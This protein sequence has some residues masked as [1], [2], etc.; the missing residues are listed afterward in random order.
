MLHIL[1]ACT[2]P[3]NLPF[4]AE[5]LRAWGS[6]DFIWHVR[7]D[8]RGRHVGGQAVKNKLLDEIHD[9]W[10]LVLD[11]DTVVH[12]ALWRTFQK[13]RHGDAA[14]IVVSQQ[15]SVLGVLHAAHVNVMIG[16]IDIGQ[17]IIRREAIGNYRI[18]ETY[19]GDGEFLSA[20]LPSVEAV[21]ID[22]ILSFHNALE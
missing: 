21:Y 7:F 19:A 12:P 16:T 17:A 1:T 5:S 18:P 9:G 6:A 3:Q 20:V 4:M 8:W 2:R 22:E 10:I 14:A 15:H 13:H 11:D